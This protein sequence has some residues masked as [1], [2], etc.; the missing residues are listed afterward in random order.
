MSTITET[1][2][3]HLLWHLLWTMPLTNIF[4]CHLRSPFLLSFFLHLSV[5]IVYTL[6]HVCVPGYVW[7]DLCGSRWGGGW[8]RKPL[9]TA[10]HSSQRGRV[11]QWSPE[12]ANMSSPVSQFAPGSPPSALAV[13]K[14]QQATTPTWHLYGCQIPELLFSRLCGKCLIS[15]AVSPAPLSLLICLCSGELYLSWLSHH[16]PLA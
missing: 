13:L 8:G 7:G 10:L 3:I 14:L 12:P 15:W 1:K 6:A 9:S 5:Y 4:S 2:K 16:F 11:S